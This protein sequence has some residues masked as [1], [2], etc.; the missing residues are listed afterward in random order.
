MAIKGFNMY[1]AVVFHR[2]KTTPCHAGDLSI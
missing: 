2:R 1:L